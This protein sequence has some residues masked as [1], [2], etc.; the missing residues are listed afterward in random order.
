MKSVLIKTRP[1]PSEV[2]EILTKLVKESKLP[3]GGVKMAGD[4]KLSILILTEV[5]QYN[6]K[7]SNDMENS[8]TNIQV[9]IDDKS[10]Q[11]INYS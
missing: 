1:S 4:I 6:A 5:V 3:Q 11:I 10:I 2:Q 9:Q 8:T 7:L